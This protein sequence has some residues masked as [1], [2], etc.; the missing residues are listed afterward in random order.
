MDRHDAP[1]PPVKGRGAT[2]NPDNR[3]RRERR[4]PCDDG[5]AAPPGPDDDDAPCR[6]RRATTVTVQPARTII[7]RNDSPDIPF[8]QSINPYQGCEHGCIYCYARPT[9]AYL[10]LSPGIDFETRLFAKPEPRRCCARSSR[11]RA[12]SATR[13]RWAPTPIRTSRSSASGRSRARIIEVLAA[14]DHPLTIVTKS[15]LV[16]R[17]LD[18]LAP[19][20]AKH[21]PASTSRS[22]RSIRS[23]RARSSRAPRRRSGGCRRSARWRTPACRSA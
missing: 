8:T 23:S 9:H 10:D 7:A 15:A 19:M 12:T 5:W 16:E 17:D 13:S 21:W 6:R 14:C 1:S 18:L 20:A 3:F 4:E 22:R 11:S 2:F